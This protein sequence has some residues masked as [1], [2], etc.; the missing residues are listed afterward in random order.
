MK[1]LSLAFEVVNTECF[2]YTYISVVF[3][4]WSENN[5]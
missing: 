2:V 4:A 1:S 5:S 3:L